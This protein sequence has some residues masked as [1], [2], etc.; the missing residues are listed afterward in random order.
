MPCVAFM[1]GPTSAATLSTVEPAVTVALAA[2]ALREP[3]APASLAGGALILGAVIVL[4]RGE[5]GR[6]RVEAV[7]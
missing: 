6:R 7:E 5:R 4:A 1:I 2:L 3:V